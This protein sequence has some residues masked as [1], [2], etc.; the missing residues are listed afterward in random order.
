MKYESAIKK[1]VKKWDALKLLKDPLGAPHWENEKLLW[2][3]LTQ[4]EEGYE[5]SQTQLG[6]R[7]DGVVVYEYQSHCSCNSYETSHEGGCPMPE[8][9]TKSHELRDVPAEWKVIVA[10]N[11]EKM[12]GMLA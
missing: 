5:G 8:D 7:K 11:I 6:L 3:F 4:R 1:A 2:V 12:I 10:A 9:T